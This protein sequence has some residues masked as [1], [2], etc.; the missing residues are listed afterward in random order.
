[1]ARREY[2]YGHWSVQLLDGKL[3]LPLKVMT[4]NKPDSEHKLPTV[5]GMKGRKTRQVQVLLKDGC[6]KLSSLKDIEDFAS[7]WTDLDVYLPGE[8]GTL[9]PFS[10][11]DGLEDLVH[12]NNEKKQIKDMEVLGIYNLSD[13]SPKHYNGRQ[14]YTRS[15]I[16]GEKVSQPINIQ[17]YQCLVNYL[18]KK[19]SYILVR[20]FTRSGEEV[21]ALHADEDY[22][23]LSGLYPTT[24]LRELPPNAKVTEI[25]AVQKMFSQKLKGFVKVQEKNPDIELQWYNFYL[26][27]LERKGVFDHIN[28]PKQKKKRAEA[29][30]SS[31]M[32][33]LQGIVGPEKDLDDF[34]TKISDEEVQKPK[35]KK[36][37]VEKKKTTTKKK[38]KKI[39]KES[40]EEESDSE[41]NVHVQV[42]VKKSKKKKKKVIESS[43]EDSD[44]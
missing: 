18:S 34:D 27:A 4:S 21:G 10:K 35:K 22:I 2:T 20:Y 44:Y 3:V 28:A 1:M 39:V 24:V 41:R 25:S 15:G 16:Q 19:K 11:F 40:S 6:E 26:S 9:K 43:D 7:S 37:K 23:R 31:L 12:E 32:E 29:T 13:L 8:D 38:K 36:R 33:M 14:Y 5:R 30:G 17:M 42:S